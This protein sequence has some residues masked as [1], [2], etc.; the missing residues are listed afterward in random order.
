MAEKD[1]NQRM[2]EITERLEQG[3]KDIF[4]SEMYANYLRTMSQFH[5]YS[6]NNTLLIHLQKPEA[7][8]VAGYQTWQKKFHRQVR[9]GEKGIQIIAPAPIRTR[10]EIEKVDPATM[11]PVL[12]PDG[13]PEMEEVEYTIPRFRVTTVFDIAQTEGEPL[14]E[15]ETPELLGSVENYEIFMQAIRDISPAPIRFDEI[16]SGAKGYYSS[17]DKEIVIQESMSESQTMKTGIHEVTHA[18]LHDRDIMEEMDEKKDQMTREVEAESVAYTVCQYFGLDTSDYSFPYIAGWSSD[19]DMKELRSSM[20]TIRRVSGEF[21]DQMMNRMQEIQREAQRHQENALFEETQ[22]RY[23]IYQLREDGDGAA[24]RF[25]GMAYLQEKGMAVD[26]ADYQFVYGDE[27]QE[28]DTLETIYTKF[29]MDHPADYTGHSLSVSDVVILKKDGELTAHYVDSFGYQELPEFVKQRQKIQEIQAEQKTYP[30]LYLSDLS[31]ASE[32]ENADAYLDSRKLNLE[33][34]QAIEASIGSHFDGYHLEQNAAAN[35]VEAYGAERVSFV[36]ACTVQHLRSDGRFSKGTKEWADGFIIPENFSRGMDL[37]ADYIVT[38]HPAVLDGF[39]DLARKEMGDQEREKEKPVEQI[40]P[41]TKGLLVEGHFGTWHT[42]EERKIAG[43]TFFRMEHD[44]YGDTVAGIIVNADGKLVAEDL[45]HGFDTGAMEAITEYLYEK[46]PEPFIKQF[47]VVNDAYRITTE[48]EY[49]FFH[50]LDEAISA[51]HQLPNH[52]EK[53]LGMESAEPVPSRMTLLKCRNGI[54]QLED[55]EKSSL[56]GKWIN[57]EV[58]QAQRKAE[59]YLDNRDTEVAY[60]LGDV[61]RYFFIQTGTEGYDYTIYDAGFKEIDGGIFDNMDVSMEEAVTQI[62]DDYGLAQKRRE[63][64]DCEN[65][66]DKVQEAEATNE[67]TQ[68]AELSFQNA[69]TL[70]E[71]LDQFQYDNDFYEYQDQ[72]KNRETHIKEIEALICDGK[73]DVI[74]GWLQ[75]YIEENN[76]QENIL[77]AEQLLRKIQQMPTG[78]EEVPSIEEA[79]ITFYAAECMEFPVLGE[80]HDNLT[81]ADAYEKYR[82]IPS[83]RIHGIKGIGFRLEDGSMYDGEYE[84]MRGGVIS[85]DMIDLIPHYKE[86]PLVQKA[87]SDLETMLLMDRQEEAEKHLSAGHKIDTGEKNRQP[88]KQETGTKQSVLQALKER[89]ERIKSQ[90]QKTLHKTEKKTQGRK[91]GEPEL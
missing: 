43:E 81:L 29:N 12:K 80:Y 69:R 46:V 9:R 77:R 86:S 30:P 59:L 4:T 74:Q 22:D 1:R 90:N 50:T 13:T 39:I 10:E 89:R 65:F 23:G 16:E 75:N 20:D 11:E 67:K 62:L 45:K 72:V 21:I 53:H 71:E 73:T 87:V 76:D 31:Y 35:V 54:D 83:D 6:F 68:P 33:C 85:K 26:G 61:Q 51:Y 27:L 47:Y 70:A 8:L 3:V 84:L 5:S 88:V 32:H 56:S 79:K 48:P 14:P 82:A 91:K 2:K 40:N 15:L 66:L 36:L 24:Y 64:I 18:K 49:Q 28:G 38:S 60:C 44:E 52:L 63:V 17:V 37:N 42:A 41:Q 19:R 25:M 7:S 78:I 55:I 57:Q 58:A 34:K